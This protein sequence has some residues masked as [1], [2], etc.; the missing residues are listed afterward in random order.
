MQLM[1]SFPNNGAL[2]RS[3]TR[4]KKT[5][6][7]I[8]RSTTLFVYKVVVLYHIIT[9]STREVLFL[10]TDWCQQLRMATTAPLPYDNSRQRKLPCDVFGIHLFWH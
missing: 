6:L 3:S 9:K 10:Q 5:T 8:L 1:Q 2:G 4:T 7:S